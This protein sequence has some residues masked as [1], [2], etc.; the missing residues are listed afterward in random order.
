[1]AFQ[2]QRDEAKGNKN[3]ARP[4]GVAAHSEYRRIARFTDAERGLPRPVRRPLHPRQFMVRPN[5]T[6]ATMLPDEFAMR[7]T[8][9]VEPVK[10][11]AARA[12]K[13][14]QGRR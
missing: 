6:T 8:P 14:R 13:L 9:V 7:P 2:L 5:W 3:Y 1:M 12:R 4:V 11:D 10:F